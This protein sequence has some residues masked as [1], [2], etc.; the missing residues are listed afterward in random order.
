MF[1][2]IT[3]EEAGVSSRQVLEFY[4]YLERRG[5]TMHSVL[6]AKGEALFAEGYWAPFHKDFCHRMYSETKSYVAIAIGLLIEEGKLSLDDPVSSFFGDRIH[7][8]LPEWLAEQTVRDMLLM[9]TCYRGPLWFTD[10]DPDR[11]SMYFNQGDAFR[12]AGTFWQYDS[13]GSQVLCSLVE[14]LAGKSLFDYLNEKIFRHL[15]TFGTAEIL[16]TPNGD[17]WGDSALVCT[18]RDMMSFA[19]F[20]LNYGTFHGKRLMNE[21]YIRE[22]TSPLVDNDVSGF[23]CY[24]NHGYG[25]QIWCYEQGFGFNGMGCQLTICVPKTD[26]IF[27]CTADNQGNPAAGELI[28][29]GFFDYI[30]RPAVAQPLPADPEGVATLQEYLSGLRLRAAHGKPSSPFMEELNGRA[31]TCKPNNAGIT[32]FSFSFAGDGTGTLRY[33]NAQGEKLLPFGLGKNVFTKFP[34]YGYSDGVGGTATTDGFLYDCA[35][36]AAFAEERTIRLR[37]QVIDRYFGNLTMIFAFRGDEVAVS[38]IPN[39]ENFLGEYRGMLVGK[40]K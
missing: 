31:Y 16:K 2:R 15:G 29:S 37:V 18:P 4:D 39:A 26:M 9:K 33:V 32:E 23:P 36:S 13:A 12:P 14:R 28:V 11:T 40:R 24:K 19:C 8:E 10:P 7:R 6:L 5:L 27:V 20:L 1:E 25:Y 22:A 34:Q 3:P 30:V 17:S 38:M 21:A 35:S